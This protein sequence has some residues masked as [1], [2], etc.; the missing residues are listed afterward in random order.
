[1]PSRNYEIIITDDGSS[2]SSG[3]ICDS[4]ADKYPFIHVTH[5][6]NRGVS[7]ARNIAIEKCRGEYV[8][9][10]DSDDIVSPQLIP[11]LTKA[12]E[13]FDSPDMMTYSLFRL[14]PNLPEEGWPVY[15]VEAMNQSDGKIFTAEQAMLKI[16]TDIQ[17]QGYACNKAVKRELAQS[18]KY[19]ESLSMWEDE[20]Y[21]L[22]MLL[23]NMNAKVC[24]LNYCLYCFISYKTDSKERNRAPL[25]NLT[26][27]GYPRNLESC[28][29]MLAMPNLPPA[30]VEQIEGR[31]YS[32]ALKCIFTNKMPISPS[33]YAR[34]KTHMRHAG[35]YYFK[36]KRASFLYKVAM[37][38]VHILTLLHIRKPRRK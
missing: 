7:H 2:D 3:E 13:V 33:A 14:V 29:K 16:F 32:F 9:F 12:A 27:E 36:Y 11:V 22:S 25:R 37:L 34:L 6:E 20:H 5:T 35:K 24:Q 18:V 1:M 4:Y 23:R 21:W 10:C 19:D 31:N 8:L 28:E 30:V 17:F 15:N 26:P 38:A